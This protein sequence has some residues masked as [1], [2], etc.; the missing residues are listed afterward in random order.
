M[1]NLKYRT[2]AALIICMV[3]LNIYAQTDTTEYRISISEMSMNITG[4]D[5]TALA[6]DGQIPGPTLRFKEGDYAVIY[7]KNDLDVETSV[8]WH[9][10]ILPN[11]YD[12]VPYL[13]TPPIEPGETQKYEFPLVH[14]G[15]YW[16]HSH[17]GL[18]EQLGVYG[19]IVIEPK[20]AKFQY[21]KDLVLVFSDWTDENPMHVLK[22]L[23]RKNEWYSIKR[24]TVTPLAKVIARGGLG[25]QLKF[26][27]QRM[28]GADIADVYYSAFLT[29]GEKTKQYP[30]FK[31]G[32]KV[33]VRMINASASTY[34][35]LTFGGGSPTI[36]SADG[37][38][39]EPV[40]KDKLLFA[41]AETYDFL[42][43]IP[44]SGKLEI[45]ASSMDGAGQTSAFIGS[46][47]IL[48]ATEV[49]KPDY[50]GIMKAIAK[51]DMK[52]GAPAM[53]F[54]PSKNNGLDKMKKY[55]AQMKGDMSSMDMG[56]MEGMNMEEKPKEME[57]GK[58]DSMPSMNMQQPNMINGKMNMGLT[59]KTSVLDGAGMGVDKGYDF[60]KST[61]VT[62]LPKDQPVREIELVL[63]GNMW[64]YI[65]SMNGKVLAES[66]K[67][68]IKKG[69]VVRITMRNLTMMNHPMHLHGHF[70][71]V[72]NKNG[73]Y[74]PLK[75]TVNV[76][77]MQNITI[78]FD[79]NEYGDWF[80]HCHIL[81]HL[82]AGMARVFSYGTP[83]DP[84]LN[85]YPL[86]TLIKE[87]N[88]YYSWGIAYGAS[89]MAAVEL[90][91]SNVRNQFNFGA[92]M[93]WN[94][95]FES[96]IS[97]ERYLSDYFR[98]YG[99]VNIENEIP[100]DLGQFSTVAQVGIR[101]LLPYFINADLSVDN[102]LRP[103]VR[104]TAEYL[105][106]R[107]VAIFGRYEYRSDFGAVNTLEVGKNYMYEQVWNAGLDYIISRN[108]SITGSYDS[109]FGGGGGLTVRF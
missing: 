36:I 90:T 38:D 103:Q 82:E 97:Y 19:S 3:S 51:M 64:R 31:P 57:M 84:K 109:R 87:T 94:K 32:E 35:W 106:F 26:W 55:G 15:T 67:I 104:F 56:N 33:R 101:Y 8:H 24:N 89:H 45:R 88:K 6:I 53:I 60:L 79:A 74:S 21:D 20:E 28:P 63:N 43:T 81:Y 11:F 48:P 93:G 99:G 25:A 40:R 42:I 10:L 68:K 7:V 18:Q 72:V 23:K 61:E 34:Y 98:V 77:P 49:P 52:M 29:N 86:S 105:I 39:V 47:K 44:E 22:N 75:H 27:K 96:D 73:E 41:I 58:S 108:F 100:N 71:R 9:G 76:A 85:R 107:R 66:D 12:G 91:S 2:I 50:V 5:R 1:K 46:G 13:T 62:T 59:S 14:S 65:W 78:E 80:F 92:E 4:K 16:Y 83:R 37:V 30:E 69:E 17:T 95:N 54:N 102:Q 70:F